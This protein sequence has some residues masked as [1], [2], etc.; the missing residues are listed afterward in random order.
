MAVREKP[1]IVV[2]TMER[3][4]LRLAGSKPRQVERRIT[5]G[6]ASRV[7]CL[8]ERQAMAATTCMWASSEADWK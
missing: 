6:R 7:I 3:Q 2:T 1:T 5:K 4:A 8:K